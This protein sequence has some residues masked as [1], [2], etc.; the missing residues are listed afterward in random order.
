MTIEIPCKCGHPEW[1]HRDPVT[2]YNS[3]RICSEYRTVHACWSMQDDSIV[4]TEDPI[5]VCSKY[6]HMDG[7]EYIE[8][9]DKQKEKMKI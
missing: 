7:L 3:C 2:H 4:F 6:K 1:E 5:N 9:L 8:W